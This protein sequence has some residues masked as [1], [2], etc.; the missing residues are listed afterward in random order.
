[1]NTHF[2]TFLCAFALVLI[3]SIR[4][5]AAGPAKNETVVI[6]TSAVCDEC[7]ARIETALKSLKGVESASLNLK[8]K[9][10]KVKYDANAVNPVQIRT[11]ISKTG[12]DADDVKA[13][14]AAFKGLPSCC[15]KPASAMK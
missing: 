13:D 8:N 15:Q 3:I 6:Q 1:M 10:I 2:K 4:V 9:K 14:Q 12:Y 5:Q 7:K 11:A